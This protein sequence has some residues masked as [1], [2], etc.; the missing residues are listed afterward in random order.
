MRVCSSSRNHS[1]PSQDPE[2]RRRSVRK[3]CI[4]TE[5]WPSNSLEKSGENHKEETD[6]QLGFRRGAQKRMKSF[7]SWNLNSGVQR[8]IRTASSSNSVASVVFLGFYSTSRRDLLLERSQACEFIT[9]FNEK[10]QYGSSSLPKYL[11]FW[12]FNLMSPFRRQNNGKWYRRTEISCQIISKKSSYFRSFNILSR[13]FHR[14]HFAS[15]HN[16]GL[17]LL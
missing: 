5:L 14:L 7:R 13:M 15:K 11:V 2:G 9:E 16:C 6:A 8:Y 3:H 17:S 1:N 10:K 4:V 12:T